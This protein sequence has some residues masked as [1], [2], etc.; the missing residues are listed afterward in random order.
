[1]SLIVPSN[2]PLVFKV[3]AAQETAPIRASSTKQAQRSERL[4]DSGW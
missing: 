3:W 4:A 1:V 2:V